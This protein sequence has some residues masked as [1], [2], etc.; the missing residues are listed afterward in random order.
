MI[1]LNTR[2]KAAAPEPWNQLEGLERLV[3]LRCFRLDR[4]SLAV[5]RYTEKKMG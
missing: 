5:R 2:L 3:L 1:C 4:V